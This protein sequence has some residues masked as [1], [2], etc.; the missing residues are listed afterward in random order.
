M[1]SVIATGKIGDSTI[2]VIVT[3]ENDEFSITFNGR[4]DP[5][6]RDML[7]KMID[8]LPVMGGTY[9]ATKDDLFAYYDVLNTM[10]FTKLIHIVVEGE[11]D[12]IPNEDG[13]IY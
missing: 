5:L 12:T 6:A 2:T 10:Y 11:L 13:V 3:K 7:E 9:Y 4:E 1:D 8:L